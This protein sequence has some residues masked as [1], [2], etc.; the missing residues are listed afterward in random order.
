[1]SLIRKTSLEYRLERSAKRREKAKKLQEAQVEQFAL[2]L[3]AGLIAIPNQVLPETARLVYPREELKLRLGNDNIREGHARLAYRGHRT[4]SKDQ[5]EVRT[6]T[7]PPDR[8]KYAGH[9][10]PGTW[11]TDEWRAQA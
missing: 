6:Y 9:Y 5:Y 1:M 10:S 11:R 8:N 7:R 3:R 2:A 4:G